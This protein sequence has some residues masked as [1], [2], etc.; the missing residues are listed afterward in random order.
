MDTF[1]SLGARIVRSDYFKKIA[2]LEQNTGIFVH[3]HGGTR[4][5]RE[6]RISGVD[7]GNRIAD[8]DNGDS[9]VLYRRLCQ[10]G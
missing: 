4:P 2:S 5:H 1:Y 3:H 10:L 9:I 6:L 7:G 8:F